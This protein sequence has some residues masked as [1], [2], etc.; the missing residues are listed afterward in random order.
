RINVC[1]GCEVD[2][3]VPGTTFVLPWARDP[4]S[5]IRRGLK[6]DPIEPDVP[7][8]FAE[9]AKE[10]I[11]SAVVF[12]RKLDRVTLRRDGSVLSVVDRANSGATRRVTAGKATAVYWTGGGSFEAAIEELR[13]SSAAFTD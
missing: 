11:P 3:S 4:R 8:R 9:L 2:H 12:L 1:G 5:P 10:V 7:H 6:M 13:R